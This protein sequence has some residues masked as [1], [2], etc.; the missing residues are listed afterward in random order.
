MGSMHG[1]DLPCRLQRRDFINVADADAAVKRR[2]AAENPAPGRVPV[3]GNCFL[4][5]LSSG[6][7]SAL[8]SPDIF[9]RLIS[10]PSSVRLLT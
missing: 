8:F 5:C 1:M 4:P 2:A 3:N 10:I 7:L 6:P 9:R